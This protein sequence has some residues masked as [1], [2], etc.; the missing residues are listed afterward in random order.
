MTV[1]E[2]AL[3]DWLM[4]KGGPAVRYRTAT[5]LLDDTAPF[6]EAQLARDLLASPRVNL[7]LERL[8][9]DTDFGALH[10]SKP[11]A[12]ENAMG[13]LTQLGCRAG[14]APFDRRTKA[15]RAWLAENLHQTSLPGWYV[16]RR[17]LV[18]AFLSCAGYH[19]DDALGKQ[20]SH[21]IDVLYDFCRKMNHDIY[22][23]R[24]D[25]PDIPKAFRKKPLVD[26]QLHAGGEA[27]YPSIYDI[28]AIANVP[29]GMRDDSTCRKIETII[30]YV[31]HPDY[32]ALRDGYG[33]M[34]AGKRRYYAIGWSIHLA[35]YYGMGAEDMRSPIAS[36]GY[37]VPRLVLMSQ[38]PTAGSHRWY[39][40][41]VAHLETF[42]T[43]SGTY[44]FPRKYL[45][46]RQSG[47]WVSGYYN[48]LEEN[49][50]SKRAIEI[51]STFWMLRIKQGLCARWRSRLRCPST[52]T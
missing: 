12:Y 24:S 48:A 43:E 11:T 10:G 52:A 38:F 50:R 8:Q 44:L 27:V 31:L 37:F 42:R 22:V 19:S 41:S 18:C 5:E 32:Q 46:E 1:D 45:P 30:E 49:R 28:H 21:R 4:E 3:T 39:R 23:D 29:G 14:M 16:F 15:S 20:I 6:D 40:E 35:G 34:R 7:W 26:P 51:E 25:Y 2:A 33:T 47:Y 9:P 17:M 36:P 13:K